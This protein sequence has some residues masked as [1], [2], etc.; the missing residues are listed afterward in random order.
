V[1]QGN[2]SLAVFKIEPGRLGLLQAFTPDR[3]AL[4]QAVT[5]ALEPDTSTE[6]NA[7]E[8]AAEDRL[9]EVV[10]TG[11]DAQGTHV[12]ASERTRARTMFDVLQDS[13]RTVQEQHAQSYLSELLALVES[14]QKMAGHKRNEARVRA[15]VH[16]EQCQN[17][18]ETEAAPRLTLLSRSIREPQQ[19]S[20][21]CKASLS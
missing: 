3:N 20:W 4:N 6:R 7:F 9:M 14:Q 18:E 21:T 13:A 15:R 1:P 2:F 5:A 8:G 17:E 19:I 11:I 12:S 16:V 10:K